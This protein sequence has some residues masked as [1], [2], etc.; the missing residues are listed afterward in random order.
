MR[1][2]WD[3]SGMFEHKC[4]AKASLNGGWWGGM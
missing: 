2:V 1:R 4:M 3:L